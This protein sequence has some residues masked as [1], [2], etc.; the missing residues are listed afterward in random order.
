MNNP[1]SSEER[2][3]DVKN[4]ADGATFLDLLILLAKRKRLVLG[5]PV[6]FAAVAALI[7]LSLPNIYLATAQIL[8][9][10]QNQS[11]AAAMLNQLGGFAGAAG[12]ALGLK[13]PSDLYVGLLSSRTVA[14]NLIQRLDLKKHYDQQTFDKTRRS[15]EK[16]TSIKAGKNGIISIGIE[17]KDPRF[18]AALANAYVEELDKLLGTLAITEAS[19]R[20][21]FFER[22]LKKSNDALAQAE[23]ELKK[24]FD[25][26]GIISV[27]TQGRAIVETV[28]HLRAQIAAKEIQLA[29]MKAFVTPDNQ[30]Y[31][32]GARELA[33]MRNELL[34]LENGTGGDGNDGG[35]DTQPGL[36][37]I[38]LL[39]DVK[40]HQMLY[41]MLARQYEAARLDESKDVPILQVLDKA[42]EPEQ[43]ISPAR[44]RIVLIAAIVGL[45]TAV[46]WT[47]W[48]D[49]MRS[50]RRGQAGSKFDELKSLL[51]M[52]ASG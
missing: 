29:S 15:L 17:D 31:K 8:P 20:R 18:A 9:P 21:I 22:Q 5:L 42:V 35:S 49:W 7:T 51:W 32:R 1:L 48:S 25:V 24:A 46:L 40:Y 14:D 2:E 19:H 38:K 36:E 45:L 23:A 47:F 4:D 13:N 11:T 6:V 34:K 37:N 3:I 52:R 28:A 43:K 16:N 12:G 44:T 30:E 33:S 50:G 26:K 41:E 10:Q 39:R 27:D